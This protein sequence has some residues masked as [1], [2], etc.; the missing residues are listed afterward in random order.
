M[1]KQLTGDA[2]WSF[3]KKL[4]TGRRLVI[5]SDHGYAVSGGFPNVST[6]QKD[7]LREKFS[8]QRFRADAV[9]TREWLPPLTATLATASGPV[10]FV[11]GRQKWQVPGGFPS[12]SHGGLRSWKPWPVGGTFALTLTCLD[13][14]NTLCPNHG[15]SFPRGGSGYPRKE[16]ERPLPRRHIYSDR[17][18]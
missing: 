5:T 15:L 4:A 13:P 12:L 16:Q 3:V 6:D 18:R 10:T 14:R 9:D 7:Y 17:R 2:F 1:V 8:A 11:T